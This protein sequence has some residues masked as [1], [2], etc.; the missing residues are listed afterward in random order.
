MQWYRREEN[1]MMLKTTVK[2]LLVPQLHFYLSAILPVYATHVVTLD[3]TKYHVYSSFDD[4]S[5]MITPVLFTLILKS[6]S[7]IA[8]ASSIISDKAS[9]AS[10]WC[11]TRSIKSNTFSFAFFTA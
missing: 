1:I 2:D 9:E 8:S 7:W 5:G 6:K 3:I 11:L 10:S 4:E